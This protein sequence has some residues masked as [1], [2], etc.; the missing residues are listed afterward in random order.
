[1]ALSAGVSNAGIGFIYLRIMEAYF[2]IIL[3]T[4]QSLTLL[5]T[6]QSSFIIDQSEP[7]FIIDQ[8]E[9]MFIIHLSE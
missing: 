5:S 2:E 6:N 7:S 1:M 4:N 3:S 8:S 9:P